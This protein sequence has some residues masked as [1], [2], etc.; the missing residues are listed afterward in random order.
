VNRDNGYFL[1]MIHVDVRPLDWMSIRFART[2]TIARPSFNQYAPITSIDNFQSLIRAANSQLRPQQAVNYDASVQVVHDR[3]GLVG[4][5]LFQKSIEDLILQVE[6]PTFLQVADGDTTRY[7]VPEGA[8]VPDTWLGNT[9]QLQTFINN[10]FDTEYWG[11]EVEWQTNFS[12]LPG[13][14]KG[15]VL[16]LNYTR[17]FS[18]TTYRTFRLNRTFIPGTRPPQYD[19]ALSDTTRTGRMPSQAAHVVNATLGYDVGGFSARLSYLFQSNTTASVSPFNSLYDSFVGDYSRFDLSLRQK[20]RDG[21]ELFANLNNLNNRQDRNFT[22]Q[23]P[24]TNVIDE[25]YP[26]YRERY[27]YTVDVG[28]R[29]RY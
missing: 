19:Y 10:D 21:F 17:S 14:L 7:G 5:S 26:S 23:E 3:L 22:G 28:V 4:V 1:P 20:V 27:G 12:Y 9:P 25:T 15:I 6:L 13:V 18:E 8:N 29:F 24:G 2:E 11:V 16:N